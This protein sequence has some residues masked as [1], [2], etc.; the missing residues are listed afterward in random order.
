MYDSIDQKILTLLQKNAR[1]TNVSL[2]Q[3]VGLSPPPC[4]RRVKILEDQGAILGYH[5]KINPKIFNLELEAFAEVTLPRSN[6]AFEAFEESVTK[7]PW[8]RS[9]YMLAGGA[10]FLI[11]IVAPNFSEYHKFIQDKVKP[12]T[13]RIHTY[14]VAKSY[15]K[16]GIPI[17]ETYQDKQREESNQPIHLRHNL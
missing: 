4:L 1:T 7:W 3:E 6:N 10:D 16:I 15:E 2:G 8:V 9:C 13:A 5:A 17:D 11:R 12:L 14:V